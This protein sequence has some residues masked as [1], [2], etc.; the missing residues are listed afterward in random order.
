LNEL[1]EKAD[2]IADDVDKHGGRLDKLEQAMGADGTGL[3]GQ[4]TELKQ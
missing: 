1:Y 3:P 2:G 4:V